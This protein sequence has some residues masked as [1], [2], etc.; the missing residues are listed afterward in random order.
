MMELLAPAGTFEA[1]VAAAESGADAVYIGGKSFS[2]RS[3]AENF[4]NDGIAEV[5]GY[6]H[7]R[8]VKVHVAAN[9]LVKEREKEAFLEYMGFLNSA[10][11]DAVIIQ[12]IGMARAVRECYPDLPLHASTQ[13]TAASLSA[14]EYLAK[15]GFTR[16]VLAR[17]LSA[18]E[19]KYI[20]ENT[21]IEIECFV[22][23]AVCMSYSGQCL[24][25]SIIGARSGN[26]GMCAQP[27]RLP[28][29][30]S[31]GRKGYLLSPK[32][33]SLIDDL[34]ALAECGVASLKIEG[35][36]K[37]PEYVSAV[38]STYRK[39]IDNP[40]AVSDSDREILLN[41]FSRSGFTN[42]YFKNSLGADMM[43]YEAS[44]NT[45]GGESEKRISKELSKRK[46]EIFCRMKKGDNF[47]VELA[48]ELGNRVSAESG[49][50][51]AK[52]ENRPIDEARLAEQ[53]LKLGDTVFEAKSISIDADTD[54]FI[55]IKVINETRRCAVR[56][57]E[58]AVLARPDRRVNLSYTG[59]VQS[60][61]FAEMLTASAVTPEQLKA[62]EEE[63][64]PVIYIPYSL[65]G[66]TK[67]ANTEYVIKL[68]QICDSDEGWDIPEGFGVLVSN[69]GQEEIYSDYRKYGNFRLNITNSD[70]A[71]NFSE[72]ESVC[73]SAELNL[74]D[75]AKISSVVPKEA[76]VYG[77]L[78][79]M[80][81]KNCP[82]KALTK[83]CGKGRPY[84]LRD[85]MGEEFIFSCDE[86]CHSI[87]LNS[88]NIMMAD[89]LADVKKAGI[90]RF[91]LE[92]FDEDY[93]TALAVIK[94]YK[95]ALE[96]TKA[97]APP[98][99][100]FTRGHFYRGI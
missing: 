78:P 62:C 49:E 27:C 93:K 5:V 12:D 31:G 7:L 59:R 73:V 43:S 88:K 25:S 97:G 2:A 69:I 63:G 17:E 55:P 6:C 50:T 72:Y 76:I 46:I 81:M 34:K 21:M 83:R 42:G 100:T 51:V 18:D 13:M 86:A 85:R 56:Q 91:R 30:F 8:N 61:E 95:R 60:K 4:T 48:D 80:I 19:I 38:V 32:D 37:R 90:S 23:G 94:E 64:I 67:K 28:Y 54:A 79:L 1:V 39:Y 29:E 24:M 47:F 58:E 89:K 65:A 9:I 20:A 57:L 92:F 87:I 41:S 96:G 44:G 22:H 14:V 82:V 45:A 52:A 35:R 66:Y 15:M 98:E 36:L 71:D 74:G 10:G 75:I 84:T 33:M 11:V 26:R 77:R 40:V 3:S 16:V 53:L 99:N 70:S 68:P